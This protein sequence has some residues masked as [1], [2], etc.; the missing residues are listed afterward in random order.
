[1]ADDA[2]PMTFEQIAEWDRTRP[3]WWRTADISRAAPRI[4]RVIQAR[5]SSA[6]NNNSPWDT[7]RH[8]PG[9]LRTG[10]AEVGR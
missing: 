9:Q 8:V 2:L 3:G 4:A 1:M 6:S 7:G 10:E 5:R